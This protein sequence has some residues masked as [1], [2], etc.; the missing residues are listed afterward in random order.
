MN[1]VVAILGKKAFGRL[2]DKG[3]N[4]NSDVCTRLEGLEPR[5]LD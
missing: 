5:P 4:T 1:A 2:K 3:V